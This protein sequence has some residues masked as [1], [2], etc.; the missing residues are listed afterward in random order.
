MMRDLLLGGGAKSDDAT[1]VDSSPQPIE[2]FKR[3]KLLSLPRRIG[4]QEWD[5]E[6]GGTDAVIRN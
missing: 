5:E 4:T 6:A 3:V 1:K 2:Q